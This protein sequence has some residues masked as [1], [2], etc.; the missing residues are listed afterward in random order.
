MGTEEDDAAAALLALFSKE[1][2]RAHRKY[3]LEH[4]DGEWVFR[5]DEISRAFEEAMERAFG[6]DPE[7]ADWPRAFKLP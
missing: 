4:I 5:Q 1:P 6:P 2:P 7:K 3:V